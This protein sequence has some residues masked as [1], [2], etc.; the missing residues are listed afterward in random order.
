MEKMLIVC[1]VLA[2][3]IS[4]RSNAGTEIV[5]DYSR[6]FNAQAPPPPA[7][8]YVPPPPQVYYAPPRVVVYPTVRYVV[9]RPAPVFAYHL[10]Y[11][12]PV[13]CAP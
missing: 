13:Y 6:D 12:R 10:V 2:L 7:F 1:A 9:V 11:H 8:S 5:R 4:T 3:G